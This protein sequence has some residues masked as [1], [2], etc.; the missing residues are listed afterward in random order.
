MEDFKDAKAYYTYTLGA[1]AIAE[2]TEP[3]EGV[4]DNFVAAMAGKTIIVPG[5]DESY[6]EYASLAEFTTGSA[7][8]S[9]AD[10]ETLTV[11]LSA[12]AD[13]DSKSGTLDL[14]VFKIV[15]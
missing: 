1:D 4:L 6:S 7:D 15:K 2:I 9:A 11:T 3:T 8:K 5:K 13:Y 14:T 12:Y 10:Y